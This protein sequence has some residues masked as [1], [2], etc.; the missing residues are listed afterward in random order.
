MFFLDNIVANANRANPYDYDDPDG[1]KRHSFVDERRNWRKKALLKPFDQPHKDW[2]DRRYDRDIPT[3]ADEPEPKHLGGSHPSTSLY[4]GH[5]LY[6][7]RDDNINTLH[8]MRSAE[9]GHSPS[10][11]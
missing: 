9:V 2:D 10:Y 1:I 8:K 5:R 6:D 11:P 3:Y 7:D 4:R